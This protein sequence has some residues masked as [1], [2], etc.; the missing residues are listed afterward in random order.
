MKTVQINRPVYNDQTI[1][2]FVKPNNDLRLRWQY[3]MKHKWSRYCKKWSWTDQLR[4]WFPIAT[5]L[6]QFDYRRH[7]L[8]EVL[9]GV[10]I[11]FINIPQG[12]QRWWL[13]IWNLDLNH[14]NFCSS[15]ASFPNY[16]KSIKINALL[17][18]GRG[19][20]FCFPPC[21]VFTGSQNFSSLIPLSHDFLQ[22]SL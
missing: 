1:Q 15:F 22:W 7:F 6:L 10:T 16:V 13:Q 18:A 20:G 2:T 5:W 3:R 17:F 8:T 21:A 11:A 14:R 19:I 4:K 12:K 9:A